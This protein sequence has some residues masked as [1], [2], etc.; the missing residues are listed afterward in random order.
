MIVHY[1]WKGTMSYTL[2]LLSF[3]LLSLPLLAAPTSVEIPK[4][5][6]Q[7]I[8]TRYSQ[9][10]FE[11]YQQALLKTQDL[12]N[13]ISIFTKTP[14]QSLLDNTRKAWKESKSAYAQTECFRFYGGPID[15]PKTGPEGLINAWPI[16]E[17]YIDYVKENPSS[18]IINN[19]KEFPKITKEVLLAANEKNGEKNISTGFHAIEFLLWGQDLSSDGPGKR[20]LTDFVG[21]DKNQTR[22][23]QYLGLLIEIL[24]EHLSSVTKAW[25]PAT[26]NNYAEKL[27]NEPL[28]ESL[29]KIFVGITNLSIDE[30]A[31]ERTTVAIEKSDQENEQNCF[32]DFSIEDL[33][34]NQQ[35]I[36]DVIYG[37]LGAKTGASVMDLI[38]HL[39]PKLQTKVK[40]VSDTVSSTLGSIKKPFDQIILN[41]KDPQRAKL[42]KAIDTLGEQ[43]KLIAQ[44][45]KSYKLVLNVE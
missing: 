21:T 36:I 8:V 43:G 5:L 22:R 30:M 16:D 15:D 24:E 33:A 19:P 10:A 25:N 23:L 4:D 45:G 40:T 6:G 3:F 17:S 20:P 42:M 28:D 7:A 1:L 26:P 11:K 18:G 44:A 37:K 39:D 35:G 38:K 13:A 2:R 29:R 14:T 12:K 34:A 31:G 27:K 32:S 9:I 41:K